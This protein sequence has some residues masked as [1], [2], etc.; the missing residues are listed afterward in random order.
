MRRRADLL[1]GL[2]VVMC[3]FAPVS[4]HAATAPFLGESIASS[5]NT[6]TD[7]LNQTGPSSCGMPSTAQV[8]GGG[9]TRHLDIFRFRNISQNA[10]CVTVTLNTACAGGKT[11]MSAAYAGTQSADLTTGFLGHLGTPAAGQASYGFNVPAGSDFFVTVTELNPDAGCSSYD[12]TVGIPFASNVLERDDGL[13]AGDAGQIGEPGI[14]VF[15]PQSR[16]AAPVAAPPSGQT[17]KTFKY[18][19]VTFTNT[20]ADPVCVTV[21]VV[22][23]AC[24]MYSTQSVAY[25]D[26][27]DPQHPSDHFLAGGANQAGGH[28]VPPYSFNAPA[29]RTFVVVV[30]EGSQ[31]G[32]AAYHLSVDGDNVVSG[33]DGDADG[34]PDSS[35]ACPTVSDLDAPRSPRNGCLADADGDG[36]T[37]PSDACPRQSDASAPRS[38]RTGCPAVGVGPH[39]TNGD[40]VLS[41]D[42]LANVICGLLG[43]DTINGLG[44]NDT[45][46][47]DACGKKAKP[48]FLALV[49]TDGNDR[50]NGGDG[51]DTLYGAGG[52]D[53]L[54]GGKGNDRLVGGGGNDA[55]AGGKGTNRYKAGAGNDTVNARNRKKETVDCGAGKKDKATVDRKDKTKGCEKVKRARR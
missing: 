44:G 31:N 4:A 20:G 17:D 32:C 38:P 8:N 22:T 51:N 46:F 54:N 23:P 36:I 7:R 15:G 47:G 12:L 43:N 1:I 28:Y 26:R 39:P 29:G 30:S 13:T 24:G 52:N 37:D 21:Q 25:Q 53:R 45:L 35:D 42:A 34:V 49:T 40:D 48:V 6:Q 19:A 9:G 33:P 16:C 41:G 55:L 11:L 5:D 18:D 50:L 14:S 3:L 10:R 2:A 27:F